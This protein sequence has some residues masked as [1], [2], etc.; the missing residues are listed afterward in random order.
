MSGCFSYN[1][2]SNH[3]GEITVSEEEPRFDLA[4]NPLP[5]PKT[6]ASPAPSFAPGPG[7][8]PPV[9]PTGPAAPPAYGNTPPG[10]MARTPGFAPPEPNNTRLKIGLSIGGVLLVLL[11]AAVV[12][13]TPKHTPAPTAY[14]KFT[15]ADQSFS[16]LVPS[17]WTVDAA[18]A[19]AKMSDGS[20]STVGGVLVH[21]N[22][23]S[24]DVTTDTY[25]T[26][27][28]YDVMNNNADPQSLTGSKAGVLHKQWHKRVAA[29]HKGYTETQLTE[30]ESA[31]GDARLAEWTAS[32]NAL[33]FGGPQHGY[34]ASLTGGGKTMVIVCS[35]LES[36]W[37]VLKPAFRR[38]L[39]SFTAGENS[40][41]EPAM[42]GSS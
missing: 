10:S 4:G 15:A 29:E 38:V 28:A 36:D 39:G 9:R 14:T 30:F 7:Y 34:R 13:L 32:G 42:P 27:T 8:A 11:I 24:I 18:P 17:G 20:A 21:Q 41:P 1:K 2:Q 16:C 37:P 6:A 26:L 3:Q 23:A 5:P 25:A 35:C 19:G 31:M 22:S 40:A 12:V 33:G